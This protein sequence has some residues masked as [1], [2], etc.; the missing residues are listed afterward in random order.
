MAILEILGLNESTPQIVNAQSTDSY[1]ASRPIEFKSTV[2]IPSSCLQIQSTAITSSASEINIL[3]GVTA[4]KDELN[5]LDTSVAGTVVNSK[6]VIYGSNGEVNASILQIQSTAITLTASQL[7][8]GGFKQQVVTVAASGGDYTTITA[9]LTSITDAAS[10]KTYCVLVTTPA[11]YDEAITLKDYVDIVAVDPENTY[12]TRQVTDNG[13]AVHCYLK[14]NINNKQTDGSYGLDLSGNSIITV[15]GNITGGIG[16]EDGG[17]GV[18][19]AS[20]GIIT[21]NGNINGGVGE[22]NGGV[23]VYT[24]LTGIVT[25][26]GNITSS[27]IPVYMSSTGTVKVKG[28][29]TSTYNNAAGHGITPAATSIF[30]HEFGKIICTHAD[31]S[32]VYCASAVNVTMIGSWA[33]RDLHSNVT[34]LVSGGFNWD[35]N[36]T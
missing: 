19:N 21:I 1:L 27:Y 8:T 34:N 18:N 11:E 22:E 15:D 20:T 13:V 24:L 6:A 29:I 12:I 16:S 2:N 30:Q 5:L 33:N 32:A 35:T 7:N 9:A 3:D 4:N 25:V 17:I 10:G 14:I 23:G 31:A 26:N 28:D 36:V